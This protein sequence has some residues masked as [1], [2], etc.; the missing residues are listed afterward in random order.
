M[1]RSVTR[2]WSASGRARSAPPSPP[3]SLL[4]SGARILDP[5]SGFDGTGHLGIR[6]GRI[7]ALSKARP[8]ESYDAQ[9][10]G[11]G[12][13]LL[14]GLVDLCARFREPGQ[15]HKASFASETAAAQAGG[16]TTVLLPPD[17]Q[18]AIDSPAM[19]QRVLRI[20]RQTGGLDVRVLGALTRGLAGEALAELSA[21]K[22]A[23]AAGVGN[24]LNGLRDALVARRALE[25]AH[26]LDL[27]VHVFAQDAALAAGGC[28]HEG[29][30]AT[31]LG[32]A[33]IPV[34]AEVAAIRHWISL[35]E[36]T[37]ARVHFCRLSTARG[38][39]LVAM[40]RQRGLRISADVAAHQLFLADT[41]LTGFNAQCHVLPPLRSAEDRQALRAAVADGTIGAICS[42]H[43]P[44]EADAKINPFP[45]TEPGISAL[46]TLLPLSLRLVHEGLLSPLDLADRLS[47][48]P[49]RLAAIEA[50][51]LAVGTPAHLVLVE[52]DIPWTLRPERLL[53]RGRNTPFAGTDFRGQAVRTF[54]AGIEV[55]RRGS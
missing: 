7:V 30:V 33:P 1:S 34:A 55:F 3:E 15:T 48:G 23:G 42:D 8:K 54:H 38:A 2:E 18:P 11:K 14:P 16:I 50:G 43:Q 22:T 53:S 37:G 44:H 35:V 19:L 49:A 26:G 41:D 32:L 40:A 28:A 39:E 6:G 10:D 45:Q 46:E 12:L 21:L 13:W 47:A 24:G 27:T 9:V 29:P 31:R 20:A 51:R 52:P 5:C 4:I 17:T 36:D 25:Y